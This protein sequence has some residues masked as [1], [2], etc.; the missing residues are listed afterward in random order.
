MAKV[1]E[2]ESSGKIAQSEPKRAKSAPHVSL[3]EP[4]PLRTFRST[5][6]VVVGLCFVLAAAVWW[7]IL[8]ELP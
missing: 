7:L 6:W 3:N 2:S 4:G 8:K 5:L 1:I